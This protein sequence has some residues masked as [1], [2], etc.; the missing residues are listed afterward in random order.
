MGRAPAAEDMT[1]LISPLSSLAKEAILV[2]L[3]HHI[4][5][6]RPNCSH[7][8]RFFKAV[9]QIIW[10]GCPL[11]KKVPYL[12]SKVGFRKQSNFGSKVGT[13]VRV[14]STLRKVQ[15]LQGSHPVNTRALPFNHTLSHNLV[16]MKLFLWELITS[17]TH[18]FDVSCQRV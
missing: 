9:I 12:R 17:R 7:H 13:D 2:S 11:A 6:K 14:P 18:I 10:C 4:P 16:P 3:H 1:L 8:L 15:A 5:E